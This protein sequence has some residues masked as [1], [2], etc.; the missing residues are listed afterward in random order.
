MDNP[1]NDVIS[2]FSDKKVRV[3]FQLL[4][5]L[6]QEGLTFIFVE[7]IELTQQVILKRNWKRKQD[8]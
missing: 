4:G 2:Y 1:I 6:I 5:A 8:N 7:I 3:I